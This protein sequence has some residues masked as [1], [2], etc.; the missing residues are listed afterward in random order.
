MKS[1]QLC[2]SAFAAFAASS[3]ACDRELAT[4]DRNDPPARIDEPVLAC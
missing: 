3:V 1:P 2:L 4:V